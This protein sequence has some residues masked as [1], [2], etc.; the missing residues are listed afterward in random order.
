MGTVSA[1][2]IEFRPNCPLKFAPQ[3]L[4]SLVASST[5]VCEPPAA[6]ATAFV[7]KLGKPACGLALEMVVP[8]P[9]CPELLLP[10]H[11]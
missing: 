7:T 8:F 1:L 11:A 5:Q 10:Q 2:L 6:I 3:Q 9:S 4:T